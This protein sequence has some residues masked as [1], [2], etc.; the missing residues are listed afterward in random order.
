MVGF[1]CSF[2][3]DAARSCKQYM[4][5]LRNDLASHLKIESMHIVN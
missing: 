5:H 2:Q 1:P 4:D 3:W